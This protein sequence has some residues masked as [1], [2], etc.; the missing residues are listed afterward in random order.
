MKKNWNTLI[1]IVIMLIL[2]V[3][4]QFWL[5]HNQYHLGG[6]DSRV[7]L[8]Q[9]LKWLV[10]IGFWPIVTIGIFSTG[11]PQQMYVPFL[12]VAGLIQKIFF[13]ANLQAVLYGLC[14]SFGFLGM[15]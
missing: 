2:L 6:D 11:I 5:G 15:Y 13:F 8:A 14:L 1:L 9:P 7:Y 3:V 4:P 10:N 12:L